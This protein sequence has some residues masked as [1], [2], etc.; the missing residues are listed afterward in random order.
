V[1][2][3]AGSPSAVMVDDGVPQDAV[4]PRYNALSSRSWEPCSK[5]FT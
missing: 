1:S 3:R 4:E 5:A 2:F